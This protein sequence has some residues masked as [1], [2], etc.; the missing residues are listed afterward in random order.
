M[1][2]KITEQNPPT[3]V[4]V[5]NQATSQDTWKMYFCAHDINKDIPSGCTIFEGLVMP[6]ACTKIIQYS[7][8]LQPQTNTQLPITGKITNTNYIGIN[9]FF[10]KNKENIINWL[11]HSAAKLCTSPQGPGSQQADS[12][13]RPGVPKPATT[14]RVKLKTPLPPNSKTTTQT[15]HAQ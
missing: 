10:G 2:E 3:F 5:L 4:H 14:G 11:D 15:T 13:A 7:H 6:K 1:K 9:K 12:R 8:S